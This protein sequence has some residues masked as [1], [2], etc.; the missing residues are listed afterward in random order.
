[1][2]KYFSPSLSGDKNTEHSVL[3]YRKEGEKK[4][5]YL[6]PLGPL[7]HE[8]ILCMVVTFLGFNFAL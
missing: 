3:E 1:M 2:Q 6:R 7:K 8:E 4:A 5:S